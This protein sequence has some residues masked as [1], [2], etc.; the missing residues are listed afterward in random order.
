VT[1]QTAGATVDVRVGPDA[2]FTAFTAEIGRWYVIEAGT[3]QDPAR[4]RDIRLEPGVDGR[5]LDVRD[6]DVLELGRVT[7]WEPGTR[8][9]FTDADG[10]DVEVTFTARRGGTRV[11]LEHR[12]LERVPPE[13]RRQ[14]A[15][16]GWRL[17]IPWYADH[18]R[19]LKGQDDR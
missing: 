4:T 12:G 5:L 10:T 17:L 1:P 7:A 2:A 16:F 19:L 13:R 15:R 8:L 3:V 11:V 14:V 18:L 9:A 6:T